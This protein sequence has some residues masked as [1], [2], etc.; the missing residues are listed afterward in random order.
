MKVTFIRPN[1]TTGIA[2]DALEPLV[3][4]ILAGLTPGEVELKLYDERIEAIDFAQPT[5]LVAVSF[6]TFSARRAYQVASRFHQNGTPVVFGGYHVTLCTDEAIRYA[7]AVVV[8]DAE[9]TWP[10]VIKDAR[11]GKL[12]R[13]YRSQF[14]P[15]VDLPVDRS[16]YA[17]KRYGRLRLVQFGRGCCHN[18]EFCSI[19]AFY[20]SRIRYRP[21]DEVIDEIET[22]GSRGIIFTDDNL[23]ADKAAAVQLLQR[24]IP[25]NV[26]WSCQAGLETA[27][28]EGLLKLMAESG[29]LT[30][31][32]G[33]ESLNDQNLKQLHKAQQQTAKQYEGYLRRFHNHGIMVYGAFVFGCD[34][35]TVDDFQ[36]SLQFATR[37]KLFLTNFNPLIPTPGTPL[38]QRLR[39]E[40]RLIGDPWWLSPDYRY[41]E[42]AFHPRGM[43]AAELTAG[44]YWARTKFNSV[45][46]I[47][48]RS[49]NFR[50]NARSLYSAGTYFAVNYVNRR[51]IHR[52][53]GLPLGQPGPLQPVFAS[54]PR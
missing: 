9:D 35:D 4:G 12:Q 2:G 49:L 8:G 15:L 6:D 1:M 28:D 17:D 33:L 44:C 52:K 25:L 20:G 42:A 48:R 3:F 26:R 19:R 39:E 50:A 21:V 18:C 54:G 16:I 40:G 31:I 11:R 36:R 45:G 24:L 22:L 30:V 41:G 32:I 47:M 43:T 51:E 23:F 13:V 5:D 38:Y 27:S 46:N 37:N 14:P 29:C 53:Q 34:E 10:Q 7:D